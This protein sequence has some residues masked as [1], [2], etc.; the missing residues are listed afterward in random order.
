MWWSLSKQ[1]DETHNSYYQW[2]KCMNISHLEEVQTK[3]DIIDFISVSKFL[4][5]SLSLVLQFCDVQEY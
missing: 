5:L 1:S 2:V 4:I 3:Q